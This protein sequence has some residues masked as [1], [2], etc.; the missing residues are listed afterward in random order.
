M[1]GTKKW[2][3]YV[4]S[5]CTGKSL[6]FSTPDSRGYPGKDKIVYGEEDDDV[7][8]DEGSHRFVNTVW[9]GQQLASAYVD[10]NGDSNFENSGSVSWVSLGDLVLNLAGFGFG[11]CLGVSAVVTL[12]MDDLG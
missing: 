11:L 7:R 9:A 2:N 4:V 12:L 8:D 6:G 5:R 3:I 10:S 1:E